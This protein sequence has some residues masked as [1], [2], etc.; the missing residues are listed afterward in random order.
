MIACTSPADSNYE[1]TLS[2]LRYAD[3][4]RKIKNKPIV[5]QDPTVAEIASLRLQVQQLL[6]GKTGGSGF[7]CTEMEQLRQQLKYS[8]EEKIQLTQAL[9]SALEENTN[10]C[11]KALMADVASQQM[12]H[13]LDQLKVTFTFLCFTLLEIC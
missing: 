3:R 11:E 9:Q 4:T 12:K 6:A 8:E 1:E 5:N 2:T 13:Q 10:M 7:S